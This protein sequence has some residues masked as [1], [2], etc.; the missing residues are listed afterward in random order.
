MTYLDQFQEDVLK[1]FMKPIWA[2][3]TESPANSLPQEINI[4]L[5]Q[6]KRMVLLARPIYKLFKQH[7]KAVFEETSMPELQVQTRTDLF[8]VCWLAII[9]AMDEIC[10]M[11]KSEEAQ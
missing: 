3:P 8:A 1:A 7:C 11:I 6:R 9:S 2:F 5:E 10:T 4:T